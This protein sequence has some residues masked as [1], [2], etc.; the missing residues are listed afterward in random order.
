MEHPNDG[1][2]MPGQ[3]NMQM[4][5]QERSMYGGEDIENWGSP[6]GLGDHMSPIRYKIDR[7]STALVSMIKSELVEK[8]RLIDRLVGEASARTDAIELCGREIRTLREEALS[9]QIAARTAESALRQRDEEI[10]E[11]S[12]FVEDMLGSPEQL[13]KLSRNT[14]LHIAVDLGERYQ[15]T[16]EEKEELKQLVAEAQAARMQFDEDKR[17][18]SD[19][20]DAHME[21]SRL[22]QKLQKKLGTTDTY[23][24]TIKL[25]ERVIAKMQ[26]VIEAHLRTTRQEGGPEAAGLLDRIMQDLDRKGNEEEATLNQAQAEEA[27]RAKRKAAEE[28]L[29]NQKA[30]TAALKKSVRQLEFDLAKAIE[31]K[32]NER[33]S[34]GE[35]DANRKIDQLEA[36]VRFPFFSFSLS[37]SS[38]LTRRLTLLSTPPPNP[39]HSSPLQATESTR[40]RISSSTR[41]R[42]RRMRLH[43]CAP[44]FLR[45]RWRTF[46][47]TPTPC[48]RS[49]PSLLCSTRRCRRGLRRW[50][51]RLSTPPLPRGLQVGALL[52]QT[53]SPK[54]TKRPRPPRMNLL[55][56]PTLT[57]R[58]R[59]LLLPRLF[60]PLLIHEERG[61]QL[62]FNCLTLC[63]VSRR[64]SECVACYAH[65]RVNSEMRSFSG[66][67]TD[68]EGGH[69]GPC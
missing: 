49:P 35:S 11:A 26:A 58:R 63:E 54:R 56:T 17:T 50:R 4:M 43:A 53:T 14:L 18:L 10:A 39:P 8:Q 23:K 22:I 2:E 68:F 20:Q 66:K 34:L 60:L 21:Q 42:S 6:G 59:A 12:R 29:R 7:A 28:E 45:L 24:S 69:A 16:V 52:R 36:E 31:A 1:S 51:P 19:L 25:Q 5:G 32:T 57:P 64:E 27:E 46:C 3:W 15:K 40:W 67:R 38:L 33:S 61:S 44:S 62:L 55:P 30:E 41:Q 48:K 47:R 65:P 13:N 37:Y 9:L